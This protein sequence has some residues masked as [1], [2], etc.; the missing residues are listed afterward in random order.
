[1]ERRKEH[2]VYEVIA[3]ELTGKMLTSGFYL[4]YVTSCKPKVDQRNLDINCARR[5]T[6]SSATMGVNI[7]VFELNVLER[8]L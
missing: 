1:M 6:S 7:C 2:R 4:V 8:L 3:F 5:C